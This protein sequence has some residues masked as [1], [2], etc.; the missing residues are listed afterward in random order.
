MLSQACLEYLQLYMQQHIKITENEWFAS[1]RR[2]KY[3][4]HRGTQSRWESY[5]DFNNQCLPAAEPFLN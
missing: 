1:S 5:L 2:L 4:L 3:T